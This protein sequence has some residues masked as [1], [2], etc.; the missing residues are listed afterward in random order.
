MPLSDK[1]QMFYNAKAGI[2][3]KAKNLRKNMTPA[4]HKLWNHLKG[5]KILGLRFR[6]QHPIDIFIADFYCHKIKLVIELDG[7]IHDELPQKEYDANR[8]E[9]LKR[10][11]ITVIRFTNQEVLEN[12]D[13]VI[14]QIT[15]KCR[16]LMK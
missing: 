7:N 11:G 13:K 3:Q 8:T 16:E 5:N 4:E 14:K 12:T 9:E 10:F 15:K 1:T 6:R 2:F